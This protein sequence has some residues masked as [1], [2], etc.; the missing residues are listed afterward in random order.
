[1]CIRDRTVVFD[2]EIN[3]EILGDD[4]IYVEHGNAALLAE[5]IV[6]TIHDSRLLQS[7][8]E[9]VRERAVREHS[10]SARS[11]QLDVTYRKLLR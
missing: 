1:M 10:W 6:S 11:K 8:S 3:R 4:G 2:N 7:L 5:S 9:Q